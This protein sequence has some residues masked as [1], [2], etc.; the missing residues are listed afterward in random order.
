MSDDYLYVSNTMVFP[1]GG[2][3]SR[4]VRTIPSHH[5][6]LMAERLIYLA[7]KNAPVRLSGSYP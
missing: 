3:D 2:T 1:L 7:S 4:V 6:V 5:T